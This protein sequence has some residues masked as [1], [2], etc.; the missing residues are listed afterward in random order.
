MGIGLENRVKVDAKMG[1]GIEMIEDE[2]PYRDGD[3]SGYRNI[4]GG[5]CGMEMV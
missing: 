1:M 2:Y 3:G 4:T 5:E